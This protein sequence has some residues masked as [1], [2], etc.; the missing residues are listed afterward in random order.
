M[1][2]FILENKDTLK[3]I[4]NYHSYGN[5][6]ITPYNGSDQT[7]V[8]THAE[9]AIY[10]EIVSEA[11]FPPN[12]TSGSAYSLLNYFANGEASDWALSTAGIIAM[13]PELASNSA[14]SLTFDIPSV[15]EEAQIILEN[16]DMP[17]YL[18]AKA[19]A[20]LSVTPQDSSPV[21][22]ISNKKDIILEFTVSNKGMLPARDVAI[23]VKI[24]DVST[25]H[26]ATQ[27]F[28]KLGQ[29]ASTNF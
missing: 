23:T 29:R 10:G 2:D 3:F 14:M 27:S 5:M 6:F 25:V 26:T 24:N 22:I 20:Q 12:M 16:M 19:S 13:S 28:D 7:N 1:R 17:F 8:L 9:Q 11:I 18:L 21:R 4:V 15:R